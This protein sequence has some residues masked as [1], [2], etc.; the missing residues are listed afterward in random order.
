MKIKNM[1]NK[2]MKTYEEEETT[3]TVAEVR[4]KRRID[5]DRKAQTHKQTIGLL[6]DEAG[7]RVEKLKAQVKEDGSSDEVSAYI[8]LV[9]KD[10]EKYPEILAQ[11]VSE[12]EYIQEEDYLGGL[13]DDMDSMIRMHEDEKLRNSF[14]YSSAS[15]DDMISGMKDDADEYNRQEKKNRIG[16]GLSASSSFG[17]FDAVRKNKNNDGSGS[18]GGN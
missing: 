12:E 4:A 7:K 9:Q 8:C 6:V 11:N 13:I 14:T 18:D 15:I 1:I 3:H 10:L 16:G 2:I 17:A 5:N